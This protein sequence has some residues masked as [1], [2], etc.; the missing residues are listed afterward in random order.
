[1]SMLENYQLRRFELPFRTL[2][3]WWQD[4]AIRIPLLVF[5][6][7]R[8]VTAVAALIMVANTS[9]NRPAMLFYDPVRH[10]GNAS[11]EVYYQ[12]LPANSPLASIV[13]PWRVYDTVWYMKIAIQGY[14]HDDGIVFPALYPILIRLLVPFTG[15]NYVLSSLIISNLCCLIALILLYKLIQREFNDDGLATRTMIIL[16]AFPTA[17]YLVAGYTE[18]LFLALTLGAFLAAFN[19]R[20]WLAGIL[21]FFASLTRLQGAVLC[22]PL[23]WIAY[24]QYR[25]T[26]WRAIRDRIPAAIGGGLG[27]IT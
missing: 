24:V 26:G 27:T 22:L 3:G 8:I 2:V 17:Y 4:N 16:A 14:R 21:A 5:V 13:A 23:A 12:S 6:V 9:L 15:D 11:G 20:W 10:V 18:T 7:M 1:M 25:D 19:K